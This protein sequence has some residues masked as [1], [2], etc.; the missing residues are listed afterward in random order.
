[1]NVRVGL[2]TARMTLLEH[3][4]SPL[5]ARCMYAAK[6][7]T[8]SMAMTTIRVESEVRDR[9]AALA[10]AHGRSLGAGLS[11]MLDDL[12]WQ[13]VEDGY[14]RLGADKA[15]FAAYRDETAQW[16]DADLADLATT[17]AEEYPE[18]NS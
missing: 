14:R 18:Y 9:L 11:A 3:D 15:E 17:A 2:R 10:R 4:I 16:A 8:P 5:A 12:M 1:V 13:G 6:T 7:Y